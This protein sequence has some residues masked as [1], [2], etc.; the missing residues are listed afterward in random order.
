MTT[1]AR[2]LDWNAESA[3]AAEMTNAQLWGA[4]R[5][6]LATL[7]N[8]DALDRE[9]DGNRG[10]YYRDQASVYRAEIASRH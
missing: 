5:D 4:I 6:I 8:S 10:G 3:R 9:D 2:Q 1:N 7:P